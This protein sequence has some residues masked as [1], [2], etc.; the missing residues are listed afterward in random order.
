MFRFARFAS[1]RSFS[2]QAVQ[3][4]KQPIHLGSL[5]DNAG[6]VTQR[7]RVGRGPGSGLGKT[8]GRGHKGQ[9][10]RSGNGKPV[11][12]FE[13]G[14]TPLIKRI[15]KRGFYNIHGKDYH[16]LNLDRLQH[17]IQTGRIDASKTITMKELLDSRC[18][19]KIQDGV[20]LLGVGS[21]SFAHSIQ[22]EVSKASQTAIDAIEKAGGKVTLCDLNKVALRAHVHPEKFM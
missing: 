21:E 13:G 15:P 10:A 8:A 1:A 7:K 20:K 16:Q 2:T 22:I 4:P 14:Q 9:K 18:I 5:A 11:P 17:W 19:H 6:A 3:P 12:G